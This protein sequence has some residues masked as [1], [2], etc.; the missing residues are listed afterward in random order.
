MVEDH[1]KTC[2]TLASLKLSIFLDH[3]N[4]V[5]VRIQNQSKTKKRQT[6][7][8]DGLMGV[9]FSPVAARS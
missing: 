3:R 7:F 1:F 2:H 5:K 4:L 9:F 6:C 8:V